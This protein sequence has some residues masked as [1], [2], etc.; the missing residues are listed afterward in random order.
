MAKVILDSE[1]MQVIQPCIL[2]LLKEKR[3]WVGCWYNIR[4][5]PY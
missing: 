1:T 5:M 2:P 3:K 4:L